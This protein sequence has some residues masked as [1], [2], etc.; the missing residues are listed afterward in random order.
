MQS[1]FFKPLLTI[2][3]LGVAIWYF[4]NP[5]PADTLTQSNLTQNEHEAEKENPLA[6]MEHEFKMLKDPATGK[7]PRGIQQRA[8]NTALKTPNFQLPKHPQQKTLPN[9]TVTGR[10]PNNYGGRTRAFAFDVRNSNIMIAGGVSSGIF[11]STNNGSSWTRVTPA[12]MIHNAT[13]LAQDTRAGQQNTW[14]VGTGEN[15]GNSA[16]AVGATYFGFGIWKSTDNGLTWNALSSTQSGELEELDNDFDFISKIIVNPNNGHVLAMAGTVLKRST[17]GGVTWQNEIGNSAS[18]EG[19][20]G[21]IIYNTVSNKFYAAINGN[22]TQDGGIWS[23]SD[24]DNWTLIR[25][26]TQ[27]YA[28]GVGRMV[29]AN[30]AN[31][32]D[33]VV[34]SH[35]FGEFTCSGGGSTETGLHHFDGTSTWTNHTSNISDCASGSTSPKYIN[36]QGAYNMCLTTKPND[37]N[38][39]YLGGVEIFRY[40]L[41]TNAYDFIGGSQLA[42]SAINLHVDNH[43]LLF[44]NN[45]MLWAGND[46]GLRNANADGTLN[47]DG[48]IWTNKNNDYITYQYYDGDINPTSG[49]DFLAGAAQDNAFTIQPTNAQ[50]LEVGPTADGIAVGILRGTS[51]NDFAIIAGF[52]G[53]SLTYVDNDQQIGIQPTGKF[54]GFHTKFH[55]DDDNRELL[56][57]PDDSP[58]LLRTRNV[59]LVGSTISN[60]AD[61]DWEDL[62]GVSGAISAPISALDASR[63]LQYGGAYNASNA[64]RKLYFG[65]ENGKVY[66]LANP[67][68]G[69]AST[70]PTEITPTGMTNNYVSDISVNP[71]NDKEILVTYSNYG[72]ASVWHTTDASVASPTW[73][74]VEGAS[75][76]TVEIASARSAM[77][78]KLP[79]TTVYLVGT[80]AGLFAT[81]MLSGTTTSWTRIGTN[82]DIGLAV[83]SDMRLRTSDNKMMLSTHGNGLFLLDF[84]NTTALSVDWTS[85]AGKA[86]KDGN[87]LTWTTAQEQ[88]NTGFEIQQSRDGEN[89]SKIGFVAGAGFSYD[90]QSYDFLDKNTETGTFYYRLRQIDESGLYH[91]SAVISVVRG[92]DKE[93][94][95]S[96]Y[97][98]P[99]VDNLTIENGL[100]TATVYNLSGQQLLEINVNSDQQQIDVSTLPK[101]NYILTLRQQNGQLQTQQFVK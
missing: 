12:G 81:D 64:N 70:T 57:Y 67:A 50:A 51:F 30:V 53:G 4:T 78:V 21:D 20:P 85:F 92:A 90:N 48:F 63:D 16:E 100:G 76:S 49:S 8:I 41:S 39:V 15:I 32:D 77:I 58:G 99:V 31:T 56:Y 10:G 35:L 86:V 18:N 96:V 88:Y 69:A 74:N 65:T 66:R 75:G 46:G 14:Y 38:L 3:L 83:C 79:S 59:S 61:N 55:L 42:A 37:P 45:S 28:D 24:G 22:A 2:C 80:S 62:T 43:I 27:L 54:Q 68:Y 9:I 89:F 84:A 11:R 44:E 98:N 7:I 47:A 91:Y 17:D 60:D 5:Q 29:L 93:E 34:M 33:I 36:T 71:M 87:L 97:P 1:K 82:A 73:T 19:S 94:I 52:Q 25:T 13:A 26:P 40:N 101:G 6:R 95:F 72:V 23:S